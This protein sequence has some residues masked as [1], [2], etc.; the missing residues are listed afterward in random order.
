M[1][2]FNGILNSRSTLIMPPVEDEALNAGPRATQPIAA[3]SALARLHAFYIWYTRRRMGQP[4]EING[5]RNH[6]RSFGGIPSVMGDSVPAILNVLQK[7]T[8]SNDF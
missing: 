2:R 3:A 8:L 6:A 4:D 1:W 5:L 7:F